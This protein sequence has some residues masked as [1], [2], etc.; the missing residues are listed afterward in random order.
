MRNPRKLAFAFIMVFYLMIYSLVVAAIYS[1][2]E[3]WPLWAELIFFIAAGIAW[4]FP[5]KPVL[6]WVSR[7]DSQ[8]SP[9]S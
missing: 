7:G 9:R 3:R 2:M 6:R 8:D 5:L 1:N 4:V